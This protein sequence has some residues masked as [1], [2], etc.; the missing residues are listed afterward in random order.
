LLEAGTC[1]RALVLAVEIFEECADLT[2]ATAVPTGG[3]WWRPRR[4]CGWSGRGHV[5][6][7]TRAGAG[8]PG[9]GA[10]ERFAAGPL[11][12]LRDWRARATAGPVELSGRWRG[13]QA[14]LHWS[15]EI[16]H[17]RGSAA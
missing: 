13:E 17:A 11:A 12:E 8:R 2:R 15:P 1:D 16:S 4:A 9:A 6:F 5:A 7:E 3:R 10:G 14:R